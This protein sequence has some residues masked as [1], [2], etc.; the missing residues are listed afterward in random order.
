MVVKVKKVGDD[1]SV[2]TEQ[3]IYHRERVYAGAHTQ[4]RDE[5]AQ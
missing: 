3:L 4:I 2:R 5:V 1:T